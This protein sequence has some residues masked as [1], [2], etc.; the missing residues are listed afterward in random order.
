VTAREQSTERIKHQ[1]RV[2]GF[3]LVGISSA[4]PHQHVPFFDQWLSKEYDASMAYLGR[5]RDERADPQLILPGAKT[6][7]CCG[8]NYHQ[9]I[10]DS[11]Q[12]EK[13]GHGWVAQYALGDDYHEIVLEKLKTLERFIRTNIDADA[14]MK[15][16]VDTGPLLERSYAHRAGLGWI[17]KNTMLIDRQMGSFF[18]LGE[19]MTNLDLLPDKPKADHCG[20]CTACLDAC[21]TDALTPYEM[22]ANR[23]ISYLTIEHREEIAP[24]LQDQ[25]GHHL[26]GCD[27]CQEVCPWNKDAPHHAD[28]GF[29]MR[30]EMLQPNLKKL[31]ALNEGALH[32]FTRAS[33]ARRLKTKQ[34]QRNISIV[35]NNQEKG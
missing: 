31:E 33:A 30:A 32:D 22:D 5:R 18:F 13:K 15:S 12:A 25:M 7:I 28:A 26:V 35:R 29:A 11:R 8:I 1:A 16:Y 9:K 4:D 6:L 3:E 27:I 24:E 10:P 14:Q 19:I 17:G 2:L 20:Q 23:C 34:W 21:P